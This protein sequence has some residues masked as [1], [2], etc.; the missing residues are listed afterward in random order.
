MYQGVSHRN[1]QVALQTSPAVPGANRAISTRESL[2]FGT[3][4]TASFLAGLLLCGCASTGKS[5][6]GPH[7]LSFLQD[8]RT[9][10][11]EIISHL[12]SPNRTMQNERIVFYRLGHDSGGYFVGDLSSQQW[13]GMRYSLVLIFDDTG[14]LKEHSMVK[15][16]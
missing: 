4:L 2:C 14:V 7:L 11:E 8:G 12:G 1:G 13:T 15:V 3:A 9:S 16:R 6:D 5:T 10:R